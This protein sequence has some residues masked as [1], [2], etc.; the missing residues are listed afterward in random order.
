MI[1][2]FSTDNTCEKIKVFNG[3]WLGE[4]V[5]EEKVQELAAEFSSLVVDGVVNAPEVKGAKDFLDTSEEYE[6]F[7]ITGTPTIEIKPILKRRNMD[8]YFIESYG[9]PE[10]KGHWVKHILKKQNLVANECVFI[11]DALADYEA[12]KE[13][14]VTFILRETPESE[15]LF[16]NF[17]GH[18]IKDMSSLHTVLETIKN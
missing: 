7:I 5:T 10:K 6:K 15:E 8:S 1:D 2:D 12:A 17:T 18:R 14:N 9:S 3:E 13:N 4:N 11:G 16:K